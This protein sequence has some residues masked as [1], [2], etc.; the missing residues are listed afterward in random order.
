M[1][2]NTSVPEIIATAVEFNV[3]SFSLV[4][5]QQSCSGVS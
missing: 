4:R 3:P 2:K 5:Y 1:L